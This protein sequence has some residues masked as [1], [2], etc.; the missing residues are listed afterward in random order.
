MRYRLKNM[1]VPVTKFVKK[2]LGFYPDRCLEECKLSDLIVDPEKRELTMVFE[3][4]LT[5]DQNDA[6]NNHCI[7][8]I[9]HQIGSKIIIK[10]RT[11]NNKMEKQNDTVNSQFSASEQLIKCTNGLAT[12]LHKSKI[13]Y[14]G[15]RLTITV[16]NGFTRQRINAKRKEL[17]EA[18]RKSYGKPVPF[19]IV[20]DDNPDERQEEV[21]PAKNEIEEKQSKVP[22]LNN[23]SKKKSVIF[24][25]KIKTV[26][27]KIVD[28]YGEMKDVTIQGKLIRIDLW[29]GRGSVLTF[30]I[31]D[32]TDSITCKVMGKN[33]EKLYKKLHEGDELLIKGKL[34]LDSRTN[35][36]TILPKDISE[37]ELPKRIDNETT[38]RVELHLH[39]KMSALDSVL[40]VKELFETLKRWGHDA[41]ALTD[42]G[43]VQAIPEFFREASK[44][45]IKPIYGMEGYMVNDSEPI[46]R[47]L[48]DSNRKLED[49]TYVVFDLETTGLDP[50]NDEIIEIGAVKI[51]DKK[52]I[53][54]M[55]TLIKPTKPLSEIVQKITGI[56]EKDLEQA[57]S[58][59]EV[60]QEFLDFCEDSVLVAHNASFDY[61]FVR[62]A[63]KEIYSREWNPPYIDT[64]SL[65]KTLLK[66]KSYS[67]DNVV[68]RLKVGQFKHHRAQEDARVTAEVFKKLI[69]MAKKRG[70]ME[71]KELEK[72][73]E[74]MN[75][76]NVRPN[77]VSILAKNNKGLKNLYKL[78]TLSHTE[79]FHGKP[80]IPKSVLNKYRDNL[81]I[82]SACVS[83]ELAKAYIEGANEPELKEIAKFFDYIE[84]MP[85]DVTVKGNDDIR[86]S[87]ENLK[88]MYRTLYKIS[89]ELNI[90]VVMTGDV[91]FLEPHDDFFRSVVQAAQDYPSFDNQPAVYLRTT[92]EMLEAAR[93]IFDSENIVMEIVVDNTRK[94]ADK[95]DKITPIEGKL[96]PPIIEGADEQVKSTTYENAYRI[97]GNPLPTTIKD[98]IKRELEAIIDHGYSVLYLIAHKMVKKS[99]EDGYVVGSRGSVGSSLVANLMG[100]T[101]VNP[102]IPHYVCPSCHYFETPE[103][104][105]S[106]YDLPDKECPE[107]GS[108]LRKDGQNIPFETFL[109]FKGEKVPDIDLNFSGE[110]Q[111]KAHEFLENLFGKDHVFRAGTISTLAARTAYG[112]SRAYM[113]KSNK[114]LRRAEID[115]IVLSLMGVRRT[116]G[117]HPGGLMIVPKDKEVHDFTPVQYPANDTGASIKTTHFAYEVIHDDLVK[118]D[119]L[120]HDDPTFIRM[121]K[122]ISNINPM[123]IPM[124]D[125]KTLSIFSSLKPLGVKKSDLG[126][127]VGTIGIPEFGTQFVQSMLQETRPGS[128]ADLVRIS[129]LSHGTDVWL[130][131]ARNWISSK[132]ANLSEVIACRDDIM[133]YLISKDI[134]PLTAFKIMEKVRKGK[135]L[136]DEDIEVMKNNSV[137]E[138]FVESCYRI[139]YLFPK[140]HAAA[141][142]SMAFRVAYFKVHHPTAFYATYF[143]I[144]GSDFDVDYALCGI[145]EIRKELS[146][147]AVMQDKNVKDKNRETLLKAVLEM[148]LRGFDFLPVDLE[149]SDPVKFLIEGDELRIPF[150]RIKNFGIKAALS[151]AKERRKKPFTSIENLVSR[152]A[153]NKTIVEVLRKYGTLKDLPEKEQIT[154]F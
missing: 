11:N 148:K 123:E 144:K 112:F 92:E 115:R 36:E 49:T 64:L 74:N 90:P 43:V 25:N 137:P 134:K 142:V 21:A 53:D 151:V 40:D 104:Y 103:D 93:K 124:N 15:N 18:I 58:I 154:L 47:Y 7:K 95:I 39:T 135:G 26:P 50:A 60:F 38:K 126:I 130:N 55:S 77:H 80:R 76:K 27:I 65:S 139:K 146:N 48:D 6:L 62:N 70:I 153:V 140:A 149:K 111:E 122:D 94:I 51:K 102:L 56:K 73:R 120:G 2:L 66:S 30:N 81:L 20:I 45:G 133:N 24:G 117:Q 72:L 42:H 119:A 98:R 35:D 46:V 69:L 107:C 23:N 75:I 71:I 3:N 68:K 32:F 17:G 128:F 136:T 132:K 8:L 121:L 1:N 88:N 145:D 10:S 79:Y 87:E 28:I 106:G 113:E 131:N 125:P 89:K 108:K 91:H 13:D 52:I 59:H 138:W 101:E 41:V 22:K 33:A 37:I 114:R 57:P 118:I 54:K 44:V 116:T 127:D 152:T 143:T 109:G 19:N 34:N 85:L 110:Y 31:T 141:Y 99:N 83:G 63:V 150:C 147:I 82:G 4:E 78:V 5:T 9:E 105:D 14:D 84:I 129:G 61:R 86:I 67:L 16:K 100:I 12:Y 97:Y 29:K 96:H